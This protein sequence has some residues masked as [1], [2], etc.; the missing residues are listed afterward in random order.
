[1]SDL[2][3]EGSRLGALPV[4]MPTAKAVAANARYPWGD[5]T[6]Q[7]KD[8][9]GKSSS[10]VERLPSKQ[11]ARVQVPSLAPILACS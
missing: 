5:R 1:M 11:L 10:V 9:S 2:R 4:C 6:P 3:S 7:I 8:R